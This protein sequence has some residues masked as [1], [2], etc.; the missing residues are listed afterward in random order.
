MQ[1]TVTVIVKVTVCDG[2]RAAPLMRV[3]VTVGFAAYGGLQQ[4]MQ[5]ANLTLNLTMTRTS[6]V[7][8]LIFAFTSRRRQRRTRADDDEHEEPQENRPPRR[9]GLLLI[10]LADKPCERTIGYTLIH[11]H[12]HRSSGFM[13]RLWSTKCSHSLTHS[14]TIPRRKSHAPQAR[15]E[16][17]PVFQYS[18]LRAYS[19]PSFAGTSPFLSSIREHTTSKQ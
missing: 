14:L 9:L 17:S 15:S 11:A 6:G 12:H 5:M 1:V 4:Q 16:R 2:L 3:T 10:L 13:A 18:P 8:S 7:C 19:P